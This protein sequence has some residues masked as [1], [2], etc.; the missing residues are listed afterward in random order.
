MN[1][2][3]S[4]TLHFALHISHRGGSRYTDVM[5]ANHSLVMLAK[6]SIFY[7]GVMLANHS[8]VMLAKASIF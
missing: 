5:L 1:D 7:T 8:L 6:A 4:H 2:F 3:A